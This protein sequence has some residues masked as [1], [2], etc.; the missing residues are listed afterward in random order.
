MKV[1][2]SI[3]RNFTRL[4]VDEA[5]IICHGLP[6]EPGSAIDKSYDFIAEFF[7]KRGVPALVF[8]FTGTGK[9]RGDFSLLKWYEDLELIAENFDRFHLVGFSMGGAVAYGIE[10]AESYSVV[11]TPFDLSLFTEESIR[12]IYS[13]AILKRTL[14]GIKDYEIFRRKLLDEFEIICPSSVNPRK[15]VLVVHGV[16]DDVVPI[17]HGLKIYEKS[18]PPKKFVR[19]ENGDHFLRRNRKIIELAFSWVSERREGEGVESIRI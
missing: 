11:S 13:N 7:S 3:G 10:G 2:L 18:K 6:Y 9:S 14:K 19:V 4:N 15:N 1:D 5:V 16:E 17:S 8:D 12:G